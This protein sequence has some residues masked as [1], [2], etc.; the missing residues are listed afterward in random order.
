MA[1]KVL[2]HVLGLFCY[3][4]LIMQKGSAREFKVGG[5]KGWAIPDNSTSYN[6]W[7]ESNRFQIGDSLLF[8]YP[9]GQDSVLH[10]NRDAYTNCTTQGEK[11]TDGHTVFTF[12]QSG[13]FYFISGNKENCLKNEKLVTVVLADRSSR[14]SNA[15]TVSPPSPAPAGMQSPPAGPVD[16]NP[17]PPPES[18]RKAGASTISMS[19]IGSMGAFV[20]SSLI[21]VL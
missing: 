12:N 7:A 1:N 20:A 18:P 4:L 16:I 2:H 21:L 6:Q 3:V 10:V 5:S 9:S 8:V 19:F 14:T 15:T 17:T 11:Y 13:P